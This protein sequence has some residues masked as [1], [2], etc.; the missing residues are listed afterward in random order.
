MHIALLVE[1]KIHVPAVV[2]ILAVA[3][4]HEHG[5]VVGARRG[6]ES[7]VFESYVGSAVDNLGELAFFVGGESG[8]VD[9]CGKAFFEDFL[10]VGAGIAAT[11]V[12]F[13]IVAARCESKACDSNH[14]QGGKFEKI[15]H[16]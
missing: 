4:F 11:V 3:F 1:F 12:G 8:A 14:S 7:A 9:C 15:F 2:G 16:F 13:V 6:S 10:D 5:E